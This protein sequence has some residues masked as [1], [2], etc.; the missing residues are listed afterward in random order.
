[1]SAYLPF[2]WLWLTQ[3]KSWQNSAS[4]SHIEINNGEF[5]FSHFRNNYGC[6]QVAANHKKMS[7]P[8]KPPLNH[9]KPA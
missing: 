3:K 2:A 4:P 6:I 5:S 8:T 7:T 1:M 9:L